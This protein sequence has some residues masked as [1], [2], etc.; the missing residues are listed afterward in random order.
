MGLAQT[1]ELFAA[2]RTSAG[3]I[4]PL[5][6]HVPCISI[7]TCSFA[8]VWVS[9]RRSE[10]FMRQ[11][12]GS[13][14]AG[15]WGWQYG[16]RRLSMNSLAS[17]QGK[18]A[19]NIIVRTCAMTCWYVPGGAAC[20]DGVALPKHPDSLGAGGGFARQGKCLE[21]WGWPAETASKVRRASHMSVGN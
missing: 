12:Q 13:P 16:G 3:A 11:A 6:L 4:L 18:C 10:V 17:A 21:G 7:W 5:L 19:A 14:E 1:M 2:T 20:K 15:G 9:L 8:W